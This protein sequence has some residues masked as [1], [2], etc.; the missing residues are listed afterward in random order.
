LTWTYS[1]DLLRINQKKEATILAG[2]KY[3]IWVFDK[4][5]EIE[6]IDK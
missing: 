5:G 2:Y 6:K 3:E 1:F 4:K